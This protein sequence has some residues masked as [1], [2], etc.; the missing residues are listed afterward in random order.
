MS[1]GAGKEDRR[2]CRGVHSEGFAAADLVGEGMEGGDGENLWVRGGL[3]LRRLGF[4]CVRV[5]RVVGCLS[6]FLHAWAG[7]VGHHVGE[8]GVA[9]LRGGVAHEHRFGEVDFTVAGGAAEPVLALAVGLGTGGAG[10]RGGLDLVR[11][12]VFGGLAE[13]GGHAFI[14]EV[15]KPGGCFGGAGGGVFLVETGAGEAAVWGWVDGGV[16]AGDGGEV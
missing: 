7:G 14:V 10:W 15:G 9:V 12:G 5:Q 1:E 13:G 2:G 8:V 3:F 4:S 6:V 11:E 16:G